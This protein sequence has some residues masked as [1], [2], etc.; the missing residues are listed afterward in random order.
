MPTQNEI[1]IDELRDIKQTLKDAPA[2]NGGFDKLCT[3]VEYVA[4][5]QRKSSE[6]IEAIEQKLYDPEVG[7]FSKLQSLETSNDRHTESLSKLSTTT[8]TTDRIK[9]IGIEKISNAVKF[10]EKVDKLYWLLIAAILSP[11]IKWV[12]ERIF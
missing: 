7:V 2:L 11:F 5:E 4:E 6:N 1:I 10:H 9:E 3:T 8:S 12:L